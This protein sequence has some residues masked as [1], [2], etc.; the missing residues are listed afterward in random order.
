MERINNAY[1]CPFKQKSKLISAEIIDNERNKRKNIPE[2]WKDRKYKHQFDCPN[3]CPFRHKCD[4][5]VI[6]DDISPLKYEMTN[7]FTNQRYMDM[8]NERFSESES[9][10]GY[11]KNTIKNNPIKIDVHITKF[12]KLTFI[13]LLNITYPPLVIIM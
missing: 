2:H 6:N 8:Y 9:I 4:H 1:S 3:N 10:N 7:K 5:Q 11:I 12:L 13:S